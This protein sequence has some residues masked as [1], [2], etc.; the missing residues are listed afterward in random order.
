MLE[1]TLRLSK[2]W[3]D[4]TLAFPR[5][6]R[7]ALIPVDYPIDSDAGARAM[8]IAE[9]ISPFIGR[10]ALAWFFLSEAWARASDWSGT[11]ATLRNAQIP[12]A[13]LLLVLA[14]AIMILGGAALALGYHARHGAMLLF[15]FTIAASIALHAYWKFS[16]DAARA[17][18]YAV[19]IRDVA[20]AGGLLMVVGLGPGPFAIDNVG[21]KRRAFSHA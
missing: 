5:S 11:V 9:H 15:G 19:F 12:A 10:M 20:V 3:D 2:G 7:R 17:A 8:S 4:C 16:D 13:E 1:L 14:L 6:S 18:E 21:R